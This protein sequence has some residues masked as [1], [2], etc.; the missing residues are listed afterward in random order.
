M[1]LNRRACAT[2]DD[3]GF[4]RRRLPQRFING[5]LEFDFRAAPPAAVCGDDELAARIVDAIFD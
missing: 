1:H 4:N 3:A 2:H 5:G